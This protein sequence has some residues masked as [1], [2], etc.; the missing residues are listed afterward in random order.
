MGRQRCI[1]AGDET[2]TLIFQRPS[3]KAPPGA[4][5]QKGP[6]KASNIPTGTRGSVAGQLSGLRA[7]PVGSSRGPPPRGAPLPRSSYQGSSSKGTSKSSLGSRS[8]YNAPPPPVRS[9]Y[10]SA[11]YGGKRPMPPPAP[12]ASKQPRYGSG[13][14]STT[15]RSSYPPPSSSYG[16]RSYR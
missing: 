14:G 12:Y 9:S 4:P 8:S 6:D 1:D 16:N 15:S 2:A 7:G 10:G 3:V 11:P 5:S 13:G